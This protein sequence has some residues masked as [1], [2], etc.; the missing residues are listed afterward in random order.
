[1]K[2]PYMPLQNTG[3]TILYSLWQ[4]S[5]PHCPHTTEKEGSLAVYTPNDKD[6]SFIKHVQHVKCFL[7]C[8]DII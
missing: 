8:C 4:Q 3:L 5:T 6:R 2:F 7:C 1:M